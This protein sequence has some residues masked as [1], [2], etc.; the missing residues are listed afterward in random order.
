MMINS[1]SNS[2]GSNRVKKNKNRK[3]YLSLRGIVL[4]RKLLTGFRQGPR[5]FTGKNVKSHSNG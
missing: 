1:C 2:S 4:R 3:R 5:D